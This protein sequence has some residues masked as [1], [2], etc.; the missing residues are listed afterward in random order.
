M[1][2]QPVPPNLASKYFPPVK[3]MST[4]FKMLKLLI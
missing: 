2:I 4:N 1:D 3:D